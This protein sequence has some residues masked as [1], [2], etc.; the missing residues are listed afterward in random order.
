MKPRF[1]LEKHQEVGKE[2]RV[3]RNHLVTLSVEICNAYPKNSKE[4]RRARKACDAIEE[5]RSSLDNY[6]CG[7]YPCEDYRGI[8]YGPSEI[9][10]RRMLSSSKQKDAD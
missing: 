7:E 8:Y 2:L 9:D 6:F 3:I 5:L 10:F 4:C 1:S